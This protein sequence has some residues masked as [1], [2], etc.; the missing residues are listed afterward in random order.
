VLLKYKLP[1]NEIILDF[2]DKLKKATSGYASFDYEDVT[3]E[4][5]DLV[6]LEVCLNDQEVEE[7]TQ[8]VH[9]SRANQISRRLVEKVKDEVPPKQFKIAIQA[10]VNN[11]I[12]ARENLKAMRKDVTAKCYGGDQTRK[13][14]LLK[15][16]SD[17][18][19]L[20]RQISKIEVSK[21]VLINILRKK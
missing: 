10:K 13:I 17:H 5:S 4:P 9:T 21:N 19:R 2:F 12:L 20:L 14:K 7:L 8:I 11:K 18:K 16:Q 3:Y 1:L 6:K 15:A